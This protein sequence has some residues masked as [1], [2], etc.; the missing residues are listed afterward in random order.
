MTNPTATFKFKRRF[1]F[2]HGRELV[3]GVELH[4]DEKEK[5]EDDVLI[6]AGE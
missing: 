1:L 4:K 5:K 6:A 2:V 3:S